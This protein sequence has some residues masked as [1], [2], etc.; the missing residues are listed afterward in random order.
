MEWIAIAAALLTG[1]GTTSLAF[2]TWRLAR[3]TKSD[4]EAQWRPLL[5]PC[6]LER[7]EQGIPSNVGWAD[8]SD[9]NDFQFAFKNVGKGA[10]LDVSALVGEQQVRGYFIGCEALWS[11]VVAVDARADFHHV[12]DS[13]TFADNSV[14]VLILYADLAGNAH[15][16]EAEYTRINNNRTWRVDTVNTHPL[17]HISRIESGFRDVGTWVWW[18]RQRKPNAKAAGE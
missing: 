2:F 1:V 10:A 18:R 17:R 12:V 3:S 9:L 11:P 16:V 14:D 8:L 4:V 7:P 13:T 5:V 15:Q 6:E